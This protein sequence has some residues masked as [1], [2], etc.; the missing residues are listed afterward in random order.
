MK[1]AHI[2]AN[3]CQPAPDVVFELPTSLLIHGELAFQDPVY[4]P[5]FRAL[6]QQQQQQQQ[7]HQQQR[8]Q[9]DE[10][11]QQ[12]QQEHTM[13]EQHQ[14]KRRSEPAN[15]NISSSSSSSGAVPLDMRSLLV[16]LLVV[17][18]CKGRA[19]SWHPYISFLPETYGE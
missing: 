4:G 6:W 8:Q 19:S 11:L 7:G 14:E 18:R 2:Y 13:Q 16:L 3:C 12:Q 1:D 15:I 10:F 5:A 17:E 9:Q